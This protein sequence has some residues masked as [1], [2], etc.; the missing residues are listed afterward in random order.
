MDWIVKRRNICVRLAKW[1]GKK[2][3]MWCW[4]WW[5]RVRN[6]KKGLNNETGKENKYKTGCLS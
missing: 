4:R 3:I 6:T 1:E 5:R 2:K